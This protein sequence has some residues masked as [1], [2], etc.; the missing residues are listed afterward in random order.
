[1][2]QSNFNRGQ[3]CNDEDTVSVWVHN[4]SLL[5]QQIFAEGFQVPGT[6]LHNRTEVK[7]QRSLSSSGIHSGEEGKQRRQISK[8]RWEV[9]S[10]GERGQS[11]GRKSS[12]DGGGQDLRR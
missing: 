2:W 10:A 6:V 7:T 4:H 3:C 11:Q 1:M 8:R 9:V 5:F 12:G